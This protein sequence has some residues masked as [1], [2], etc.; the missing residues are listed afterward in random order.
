MVLVFIQ[1]HTVFTNTF[2]P[3]GVVALKGFFLG[4]DRKILPF[5]T[6]YAGIN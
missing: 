1:C 4:I 5:F 6:P 2:F 3:L